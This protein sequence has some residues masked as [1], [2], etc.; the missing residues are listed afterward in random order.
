MPFDYLNKY[1]NKTVGFVGL[2][3]SNLPTAKLMQC[4]NINVVLRDKK[5]QPATV[6]GMKCISGSGYL[7]SITED[8]LFLAPAVRDDL[9]QISRA[10]AGGVIVTSE[11]Q[12]F[13]L[14]CPATVIAVTGSDGKTTTTTIISKL[15][16]RSG[17]RVFLGGNIGENLFCRLEEIMPGD[18]AV[19]ELSSF[20]LMKMTRSP[21]I[22]VITNVAPNHLDWHHGMAEYIQSKKR[23]YSQQTEKD[24]CVLNLD[25]DTTA[26]FA[27]NVP[28]RTIMTSGT[29]V[30]EDGVYFN[31][32]GIFA[33]GKKVLDDSDIL[34]VGVHNRYNYASAIAATYG[35]VS[36]SDIK[37]V[38]GSFGGVK[39]RGELV[40]EKDGIKYY[41]SSIDSSPTR[42][43]AALESF[44]NK[45]IVICGG[46]DKKIPLEPL[47]ELFC[48]KAKAVI[49]MGVTGEEIRKILNHHGFSGGVYTAADMEEAVT[50]AR[51]EAVP[52]DVIILSPA[53]A[54]FDMYKNFEE[55]GN[56]FVRAV[57]HINQEV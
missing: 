52:G 41:N 20:Q 28:G 45:V 42:T 24:I 31:R 34:L 13:L 38:A 49:T 36:E 15:L 29:S 55:R 1:K 18:Y 3:I 39:H 14:L 51:S 33:F 47:G 2:G 35:L 53:A 4:H 43:K 8:F 44:E 10:K 40:A 9:E 21:H 22:A 56:A 26:S 30:L 50:M 7:D 17:K 6:E 27:E 37:A 11:M 19:C 25:N 46:Y 32:E 16:E 5:E 54:S 12:E 23:I 48:R 57:S